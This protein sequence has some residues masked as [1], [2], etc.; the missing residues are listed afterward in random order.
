[1]IKKAILIFLCL[2]G[3]FCYGQQADTLRS[4]KS[5]DNR[6]FFAGLPD[7]DTLT[8][9]MVKRARNLTIRDTAYQVIEFS[10]GTTTRIENRLIWHEASSYSDSFS[11][12]IDSI[13]AKLQPGSILFVDRA[14]VITKDGRKRYL[15]PRKFYIR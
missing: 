13:I 3:S 10:A 5:P 15:I 12:D 2:S 11:P 8:L 4:K 7:S 9:D 6:P 1:M 14:A